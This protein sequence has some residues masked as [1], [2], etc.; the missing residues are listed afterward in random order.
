MKLRVLCFVLLAT[1]CFAQEIHQRETYGTLKSAQI[2]ADKLPA[3]KYLQDHV[4]NG[5]CASVCRMQL[6]PP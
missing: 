2:T 6:F 1:S 4:V 5:S 3:A